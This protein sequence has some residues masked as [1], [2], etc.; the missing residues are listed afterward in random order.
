MTAKID[1][2]Q[3][4]LTML[5]DMAQHVGEHLARGIDG[6]GRHPFELAVDVARNHAQV[7]AI[8]TDGKVVGAFMT[9]IVIDENGK[10][11]V[12]VFGLAG[13]GIMKWGRVLS[14]RMVDFAKANDCTRVVFAGRWG[15]MRAY[16]NL[17]VITRKDANTLVYQ[18]R[19]A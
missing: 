8:F 19:V 7:W 12:D 17:E 13:A 16:G 14:D 11:S 9:A 2:M 4:P 10:K 3:I 1:I 15:L 18:R 5:P 6:S